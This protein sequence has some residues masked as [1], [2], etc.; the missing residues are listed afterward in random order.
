MR[1]L[2]IDHGDKRIG[3]SLSDESGV[4]A[5]PFLTVENGKKAID[6]IKKICSEQGVDIIVMG[7]PLSFSMKETEQTKKVKEFSKKLCKEIDLPIEFENEFLT[8]KMAG[9]QGV[10]KQNIDESSAALI[11]QGWLDKNKQH[12]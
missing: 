11:L 7:L 4:F 5:F 9:K 1:Y 8:S 3:I 10:G 2:G 12:L 6:E